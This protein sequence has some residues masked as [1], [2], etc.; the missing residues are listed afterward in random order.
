MAL[1][2]SNGISGGKKKSKS[3][4]KKKKRKRLIEISGKTE[5]IKIGTDVKDESKLQKV[6]DGF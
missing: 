2:T 1:C 6:R 5:Q 4:R 3:K